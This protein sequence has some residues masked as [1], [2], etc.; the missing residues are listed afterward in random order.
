MSS[1]N[2]CPQKNKLSFPNLF[3][4]VFVYLSEYQYHLKQKPKSSKT[5]SYLPPIV[6]I[7]RCVPS[8]HCYS[9]SSKIQIK[10]AN[11][12]SRVTHS[13]ADVGLKP[14][15]VLQ[16]GIHWYLAEG[17]N[18]LQILLCALDIVFYNILCDYGC[19]GQV[20]QSDTVKSGLF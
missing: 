16:H 17:C 1:S 8:S 13:Q 9:L 14:N 3:L 4:I 15:P 7:S 5:F 10:S 18:Q 2:A 12:L 6:I 19:R 20:Q 11:A